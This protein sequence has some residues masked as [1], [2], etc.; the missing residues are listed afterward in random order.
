MS[1]LQKLREKI[2]Q[3]KLKYNRLQEENSRLKA[4][5]DA[6]AQ[7]KDSSQI[8]ALKR[9]LEEKDREIEKIITQVEALLL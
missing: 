1:P 6:V 4:D 5:L 7:N 9:E 2:E 3:W 8:I